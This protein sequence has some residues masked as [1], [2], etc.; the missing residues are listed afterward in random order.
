L[1]EFYRAR[2]KGCD[3]S[4][5][6]RKLKKMV[7]QCLEKD[8]PLEI[9]MDIENVIQNNY[10]QK[11]ETPRGTATLD[12]KDVAL[13]LICPFCKENH[14]YSLRSLVVTDRLD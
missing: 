13:N 2:C 10:S 6:T 8:I 3:R 9:E 7:I 14:Q 11:I 12:L 4:F 5:K 1:K